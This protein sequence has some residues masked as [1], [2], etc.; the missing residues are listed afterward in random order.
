MD[1]ADHQAL[2]EVRSREALRFVWVDEQGWDQSCGYAALASLMRLYRD[3]PV[4]ETDLFTAPAPGGTV[5]KVTLASLV[6]SA[7]SRGLEVRPWRCRW[8]D[9]TGLLAASAPLLVHYA[10]PQAHFA[11]L[12]AAGDRG[13]VTADPAR[14]V[15]LLTRDQFEARWSGVAVEVVDPARPQS[16]ASVVERA[17]EQTRRRGARLDDRPPSPFF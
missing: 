15:E 1:I 17:V 8:D 16:G 5:L 2:A 12:L 3:Q 13:A 4:H 10:H 14:G 6:A 11:L 7:R 9:L